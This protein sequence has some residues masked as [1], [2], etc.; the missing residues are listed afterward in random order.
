[1]A[2]CHVFRAEIGVVVGVIM[3]EFTGKGKQKL[4]L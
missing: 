4:K 2:K 1:M 3:M